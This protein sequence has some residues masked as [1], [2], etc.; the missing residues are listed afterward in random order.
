MPQRRALPASLTLALTK[1]L[2]EKVRHPLLEKTAVV[3]FLVLLI[4]SLKQRLHPRAW[5]P[6]MAED[7]AGKKVLTP[8][9]RRSLNEFR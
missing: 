2:S 5:G 1:W 7:I 4:R 9:L 8:V 6:H 3:N